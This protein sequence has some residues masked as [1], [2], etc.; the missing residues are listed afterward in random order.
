[1]VEKGERPPRPEAID[2][3]PSIA[4]DG[5]WRLVEA[6]WA[7][8]PD[9]RPTASDVQRA[10]LNLQGGNANSTV[11]SDGRTSATAETQITQGKKHVCQD[12]DKAFSSASLLDD[13]NN[14]CHL[15]IR[16]FFM[17]AM[18]ERN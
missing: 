14:V 4:F 17:T 1:M 16:E 13:H 18:F 11:E 3:S 12:C 2:F 7:Q 8:L 15:N 6:C 5:L 10:I 9:E